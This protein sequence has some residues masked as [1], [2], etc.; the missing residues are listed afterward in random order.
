VQYTKPINKTVKD[1]ARCDH[2]LE[3]EHNSPSTDGATS[4]P[5][6]NNHRRVQRTAIG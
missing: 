6:S 5:D 3:V 4:K 2:E 1:L